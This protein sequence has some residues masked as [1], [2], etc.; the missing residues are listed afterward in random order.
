MNRLL[1]AISALLF[2]AFAACTK[3]KGPANGKSVQPNNNLDTL[4]SMYTL[5]NRATWQ[6]DSVFGYYAYQANNDSGFA[7]LM[8]TAS[9]PNGNFTNT[10]KLGIYNFTGPG[11]YTVSPPFTTAA[12]Y[13]GNIRHFATSG[14]IVISSNTPYGLIGTFNFIA[15]TFDITNGTFNVVQP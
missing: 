9:G 11:T 13:L 5:I 8:I 2:I 12:Y 7:N 10:I 15:D 14:A 1:I 4:V 6:T 3:A